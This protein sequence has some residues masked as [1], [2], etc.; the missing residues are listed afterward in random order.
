[1]SSPPTPSPPSQQRKPLRFHAPAPAPSTRF[2]TVA[3]SRSSSTS[4]ISSA[5]ASILRPLGSPRRQRRVPSRKPPSRT[6]TA[7]SPGNVFLVT[8]IAP[9]VEQ[10]LAI[11]PRESFAQDRSSNQVGCRTR[12]TRSHN[13]RDKRCERLRVRPRRPSRTA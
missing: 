5:T 13:E 6:A 9:P 3:S 8:V 1:M 4:S 11:L 2:H 10:E 7:D 12:P